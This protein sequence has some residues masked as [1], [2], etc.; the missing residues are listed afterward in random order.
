LNIPILFF[1]T[2]LIE[3]FLFEEVLWT[4]NHLTQ[5]G[6]VL[7]WGTSEWTGVEIPFLEQN[8]RKKN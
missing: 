8:R 5:Q 7:Y 2:G 3:M 1:A 6:K 4:M